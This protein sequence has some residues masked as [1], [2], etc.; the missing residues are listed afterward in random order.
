VV[1]AVAVAVHQLPVHLRAA[2]NAAVAPAVAD[3]A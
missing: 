3:Q 2:V 1:V